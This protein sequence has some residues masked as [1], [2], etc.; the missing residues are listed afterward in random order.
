MSEDPKTPATDAP[1]DE[2]P[3]A[4]NFIEAAVIE[5]LQAGR[6]T[7]PL[8][9]R[10][11][12]EPNGYWHIGHVYALMISY[13][14][15]RKYGGL[16]NLRFDDTNPA[17]EKQEFVDAALADL[18]WLGIEVTG[19]QVYSSD[20]F[21]QLY[22][23]AVKL[24]SSGDAYVC[25]L[26]NDELKALRGDFHS[27]GKPS[28]YRDRS[29][30]ENLDL[31]ARMR[32]GEFPPQSKTLRAKIDMASPNMTLRDPI[33]YRIMDEEHYRLGRDWPIY[34]AYDFAQSFNDALDGV[35][36]SLCSIEFVNHRP[37]YDWLL[38]KAEVVEPPRQIEFAK[39]G[40]EGAVIGKRHIR[41]LVEDGVLGGWDD[42]RLFTLRGMRR[43][44]MP[45]EAVRAFCE[46]LGVSRTDASIVDVSLLEH[47]VREQ[48]NRTAPR[49]MVVMQ[50]IKLVVENIPEGETLVATLDNNPE[51]P[52]AGTRKVELGRELYIDA[53]DFL[54]DPPKKY[55]RLAPDK[56]VRLR[57]SAVI[58]CTGYE[59]DPETGKVTSVRATYDP[60]TIGQAP[61]DGRRIRGVI[62]WV[63]AHNCVNL[64]VRI[65]DRLVG[66]DGEIQPN[67]RSTTNAVGEPSVADFG[68]EQRLQFERVGY[69]YGD[70]DSTGEALVFN[71]T[72]TLKDSWKAAQARAKKGG[73]G[74]KS[75]SR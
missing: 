61:P 52:E 46:R 19:K 5:D 35:T 63:S 73:G 75:S 60:E 12:P 24:I 42:P 54:V 33:L 69:F 1:S 66:E 70:P 14:V 28:P 47:H 64:E 49:R 43:R 41:P 16:F 25:D 27:P 44:G 29:V 40:V 10:F 68:P 26:S 20:F 36:H 67:S 21:Q 72:V 39:V 37:L 18:E 56:E 51:D 55:W 30:E 50:P 38:E 62:H 34:P 22:D 7:R 4:A 65:F 23:Y 31:F 13:N 2:Y 45:P 32:G 58:K 17:K 57:G 48:L 6:Y 15:A 59:T 71:R 53:N 9:T 3:E 8:C 74:K 11:P